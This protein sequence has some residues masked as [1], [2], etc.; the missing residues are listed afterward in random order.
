MSAPRPPEAD[1]PVNLSTEGLIRAAVGFATDLTV[2]S[3][4]RRT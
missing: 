1:S 3:A 4:Q 2:D